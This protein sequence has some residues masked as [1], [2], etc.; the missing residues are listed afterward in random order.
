[1]A[2]KRRDEAFKLPPGRPSKLTDALQAQLCDHVDKCNSLEDAAALCGLE[3]STVFR[4]MQKGREQSRGRYR[5]FFNAIE[6][7]K[8]G[9]RKK[10][11]AT[12]LTHGF[13][14]WQALA[15]LAERTDPERFGLRIKVQ[16]NEELERILDKLQR[17]LTPQEYERALEAISQPDDSS[18]ALGEDSSIQR[19]PGSGLSV[20]VGAA[21][22]AA[23]PGADA[24]TGADGED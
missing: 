14:H 15:W 5:D 10:F 18:E 7:A 17:Q 19:P 4:W 9:R 24:S 8:A 12:M 22:D 6:A 2:T 11:A 21:L 13:K 16:V 20:A 23:L 1:M 3:R